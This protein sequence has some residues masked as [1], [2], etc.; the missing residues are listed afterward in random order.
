MVHAFMFNSAAIFSGYNLMSS[1]RQCR[2]Y[3]GMT[4]ISGTHQ[5]QII[6]KVHLK[7]LSSHILDSTDGAYP[8]PSSKM[9]EPS[10]T[11][12]ALSRTSTIVHDIEHM[13]VDDDP[14]KWSPLRK[15]RITCPLTRLFGPSDSLGQNFTLFLVASASMIA[16]LSSNI[17]NRAYWISLCNRDLLLNHP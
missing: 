2:A 13:P 15:V 12:P 6:A 4:G 16:G 14:R 5:K 11:S 17:Q 9:P 8:I 1:I 7:T 10:L 3:L